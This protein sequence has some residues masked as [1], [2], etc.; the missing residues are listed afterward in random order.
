M[1]L[2]LDTAQSE[3][4][5]QW[6]FLIDGVTTNPST[7]AKHAK[8]PHK[9]LK[10]ICQLMQSKEV[11]IEVTEVQPEKVYA[12][13]QKIAA[14][15]DNVVVKIP[16]QSSYFSLIEKLTAQGIRTNITL[17]F[18]VFQATLMAKLGAAYVSPFVGRLEDC[19]T[20]G[21]SLLYDIRTAFDHYH[22]TTNILAASIRSPQHIH[23]ALL[24][25]AD[26][27]T[28]PVSV[29]QKA[30]YHPLTQE[31]TQQFLA[32]WNT[33]HFTQFP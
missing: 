1:K 3:Q 26:A 17:V 5:E 21:T 4:V 14:F 31:G 20:P 30:I 7:V 28:V 11:S 19:S 9:E 6:A 32:D 18:T 23:E 27:L 25:G 29:L 2:F 8:D 24:A 13:A 16:C 15:A 22:Y 10:K 33:A 12:Q